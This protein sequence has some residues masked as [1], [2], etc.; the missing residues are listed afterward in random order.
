MSNLAIVFTE[1]L[2][3]QQR[4]GYNIHEM[5]PK[6]K[7]DYIKEY[8]IHLNNEMN[9]LLR[10]L[11]HFKPWKKYNWSEEEAADR[12]KK[13]QE[14]YIDVLH[15]FVII[16]LALDLDATQVVDLYLEKNTVNHKRQENTTDYK[17]CTDEQY[18]AGSLR[19]TDV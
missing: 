7:T 2:R 3:L 9:E 8:S 11:P 10:E 13:A 6:E 18:D 12:L 16:G 17:R 19:P 1:Q 15:F 4:L 5:S 14:E